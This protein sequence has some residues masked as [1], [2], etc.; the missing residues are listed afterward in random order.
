[1]EEA[2]GLDTRFVK[3]RTV[4]WLWID[5]IRPLAPG[6]LSSVE[7]RQARP[8]QFCDLVEGCSLTYVV[9]A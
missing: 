2:T 5:A 1:M 3:L 7:R 9:P 8:R 4:F 6:P